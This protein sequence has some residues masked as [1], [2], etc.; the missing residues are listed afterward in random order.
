MHRTRR[1]DCP[2]KRSSTLVRLAVEPVDPKSRDMSQENNMSA[3]TAR[4]TATKALDA[5][6]LLKSDHRQVEQWFEDF[7]KARSSKVKQALVNQICEALTIHSEIEEEIFYPAFLERTKDK[8][9]HHQA[10]VEHDG[11]K[12]LI[13]E[14]QESNPSDEFFDSKVRVLS[15]M[16]KHHVKDEE[17]PTGMFAEA[18]KSNLDL[19][20]L[21]QQLSAR[22]RRLR[23]GQLPGSV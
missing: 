18:K 9:I 16:I 2:L 21:G 4:K 8:D 1:R 10:I 17:K 5:V 6:A 20:S 3:T 15:E 22:Q 13:A 23:R 7:K 19:A 11:A 12:K 14:I